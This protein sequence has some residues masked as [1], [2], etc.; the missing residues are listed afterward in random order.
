MKQAPNTRRPKA[1]NG[2]S[3]ATSSTRRGSF[4]SGAAQIAVQSVVKRSRRKVSM[5]D[6]CSLG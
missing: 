3:P 2:I 4:G 6:E 5:H 1:A